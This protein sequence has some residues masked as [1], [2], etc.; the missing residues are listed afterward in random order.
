MK[1]SELIK[2]AGF[3]V[4]FLAVFLVIA[5]IFIAF[6]AKGDDV[7]A[8]RISAIYHHGLVPN[9][10][11]SHEWVSGDRIQEKI[12]KFGFRSTT[13]DR[14]V[15]NLSEYKTVV[16]GDSFV[17]GVGLNYVDTFA[18][19]LPAKF[20][21]VANMGVISYSPSLYQKKLK[22]YKS[23]GLNPRILIQVVD[24]SDIQDEYN[25]YN[26]GFRQLPT[27]PVI[28]NTRLAKTI[29]YRKLISLI[30][31]LNS[32]YPL[33]PLSES[34]RI[35]DNNYYAIRNP[36]SLENT[37]SYYQHGKSLLLKAVLQSAELF[38]RSRVY[39]LAYDW[40][41]D[42]MTE[43]GSRLYREYLADLRATV[44]KTS[45]STF[46][47]MTGVV[48]VPSGYIEG[49]VHWNKFGNQQIVSSFY[50]NCFIKS[51]RKSQNPA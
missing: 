8:R 13:T 29:L 40:G 4:L 43:N 49:D 37:P 42:K 27:L 9:A 7:S 26:K 16:I 17:E 19:I 24:V 44:E 23:L 32:R 46:C 5:D 47:D 51:S 25:Y 10:H 14:Q 50:D 39:V 36:Y 1:K 34:R 33:I 11:F 18:S 12:N 45:N 31:K 28:E 6:S 21:P 15:N 38:P 2:L 20:G 35:W 41:P 3:N 22:H 30:W 48:K